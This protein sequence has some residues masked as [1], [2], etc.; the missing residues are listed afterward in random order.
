MTGYQKHYSHFQ[1]SWEELLGGCDANLMDYNYR[2]LK[3]N[4]HS[5]YVV[6]AGLVG[7]KPTAI[8][9]PIRFCLSS[10]GIKDVYCLPSL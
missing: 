3:K 5:H 10:A 1:P 4:R 8:Q 7:L 2:F 6:L 9:R